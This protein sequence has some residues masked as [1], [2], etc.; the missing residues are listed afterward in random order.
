MFAHVSTKKGADAGRFIS[1]F[2]VGEVIQ[3]YVSPTG[4][5]RSV[6]KPGVDRRVWIQTIWALLAIVGWHAA[7]CRTLEIEI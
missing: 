6:I 5:K 7:N 4:P 2:E 1:N 3:V